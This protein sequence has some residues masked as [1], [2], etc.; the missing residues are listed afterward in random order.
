MQM[1]KLEKSSSTSSTSA[2]MATMIS[3][4]ESVFSKEDSP[5]DGERKSE[6][7]GHIILTSEM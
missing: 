4:N 7:K 3:M 2:T 6:E 1:Q 5:Y